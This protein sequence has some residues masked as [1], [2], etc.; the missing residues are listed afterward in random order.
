[1]LPDGR[2]IDEII[3]FAANTSNI[4]EYVT[5]YSGN[6]YSTAQLGIANYKYLVVM[7]FPAH[8]TFGKM[9]S[10]TVTSGV[11][12]FQCSDLSKVIDFREIMTTQ[13]SI[14]PIGITSLDTMLGGDGTSVGSE[15]AIYSGRLKMQIITNEANVGHEI[16][17]GKFSLGTMVDDNGSF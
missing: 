17:K 9:Q 10:S 3:P 12:I 13:I 2:F 16:V 7:F 11:V 1:M 5:S 15:L 8:T 4:L 14:T 6:T